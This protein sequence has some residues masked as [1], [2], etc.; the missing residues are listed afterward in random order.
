VRLAPLLA[1][2]LAACSDG[3]SDLTIRGRD[4]EEI[5]RAGYARSQ[6]AASLA[7]HEERTE[8]LREL[9]WRASRLDPDA[10]APTATAAAP[11]RFGQVVLHDLLIEGFEGMSI[12]ATLYLPRAA[13][14]GAKVPGVLVNVGHDAAGQNAP[15]AR[16]ICW[17][18]ATNG[19]GCL[20]MDWL[21]MGS[22]FAPYHRH[23]PLGLRSYLA[24]LLPTEPLLG[25]PLAAWRYLAAR[26]EIDPT[27]VAMAGQSGGGMVTMHLAAMEPKIAAAVVVDIV[28]SNRYQFETLRGWGDPDSFLP[29]FHAAGGHGDLLAMI[30]PRPLLVLSSDEDTIGPTEQAQSE[31]AIAARAFE[32]LGA[33]AA[34]AHSGYRGLVPP[35]CWCGGKLLETEAFLASALTG[36]VIAT[37]VPAPAGVSGRAVSP[38]TAPRWLEL[39]LPRLAEAPRD[40]VAADLRALVAHAPRP[41]AA[42]LD[43]PDEVSAGLLWVGEGAPEIEG[44]WV[45]RFEADWLDLASASDDV[46]RYAAQRA[47]QL[48]RSLLG[49]ATD[50]LVWAATSMRA[51]GAPRVIAICDG[52]QAAL[53]CL[54]AAA[55]DGIFDAIAVRGLPADF[56]SVLALAEDPFLDLPWGM[57]VTPDLGAVASPDLLLAATAPRP[58]AVVGAGPGEF[59]IT[60]ALAG[61]VAFADIDLLAAARRLLQF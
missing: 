17:T 30:A 53:A 60:R 27:R 33:A 61:D 25:E 56:Q 50:D 39:L 20:T 1:C 34:F 29:G 23:V 31:F 3:A 57:L 7:E 43:P 51:A 19:I 9:L 5:L 52:E 58:L 2:G 55:H 45:L 46:R 40:E 18:L 4:L 42:P 54:A 10:P 26:P 8:R 35:H 11:R 14:P 37:S 59:P 32:L 48:G 13:S 49:Y 28:A 38:D 6:P 16:E 47:I 36:Q 44:A 24:G 15:Y 21:G 41:L 22:R 12:P